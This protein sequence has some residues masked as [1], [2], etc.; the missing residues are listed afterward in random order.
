MS[1]TRKRLFLLLKIGISV[2]LISLFYGGVDR[3]KLRTMLASIDFA[4]LPL[5]FALLLF[6]SFISTVKWRVFLT[7]SGF[8]TS[9]TRLFGTYLSASFLNI[10]LP[11]NIGGDFYRIYDAGVKTSDSARSTASVVADRLSGFLAMVIFGL[12]STISGLAVSNNSIVLLLPVVVFSGLIVLIYLLYQ[13]TILMRVLKLLGAGRS[14]KLTAKLDSFFQAFQEYRKHP[15]LFIRVMGISFLFQFMVIVFVYLMAKALSIDVPFVFFCMYVPLISLL[16]SI[17]LSIFGLGFREGGYI[18]FMSAVG[19]SEEAG[20]LLAFVYV[21]LTLL[22]SS[23]GGVIL[24]IR[25]VTDKRTRLEK[26]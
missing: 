18:V 17:P 26:K 16:E 21:V 5:L 13:R 24:A 1:K 20:L 23:V 3:I 10:F 8:R 11:S 25:N 6:N 7:A 2:G 22:F 4:A 14:E 9:L 12:I 19:Q 15:N